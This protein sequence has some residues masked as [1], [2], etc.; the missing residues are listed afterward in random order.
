MNSCG[1]THK[2]GVTTLFP[3]TTRWKLKLVVIF[4]LI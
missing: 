3:V 1:V 2:V 4:K